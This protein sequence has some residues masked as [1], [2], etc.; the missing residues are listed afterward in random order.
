MIALKI[1]MEIRII[2]IVSIVNYQMMV[3]NAS[4]PQK[5]VQNF[6]YQYKENWK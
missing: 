4:E 2:L 1:I 5:D 6:V 3:V